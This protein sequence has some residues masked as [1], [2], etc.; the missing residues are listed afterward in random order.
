[1]KSYRTVI[2]TDFGNVVVPD[3]V[4]KRYEQVYF[5]KRAPRKSAREA[6]AALER[7]VMAMHHYAWLMGGT[8][9]KW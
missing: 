4:L 5:R 7:D 6:L 9:P 1:M 2:V 3:K 8:E